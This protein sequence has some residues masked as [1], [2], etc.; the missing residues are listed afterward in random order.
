MYDPLLS[1]DPWV[2]EYGDKREATGEARGIRRSIRLT[3]QG[4]FP[5]L[6]ELA[7][8]RVEQVQDME[9]LEKVQ[10]AMSAAQDEREARRF[11]LAMW[12]EQ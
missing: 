5:D 9:V 11:L 7:V 2:Q 10:V 1:E 12:D 6:I 8:E 4:R 3:V